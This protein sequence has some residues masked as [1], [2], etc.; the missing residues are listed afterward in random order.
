MIF[1]YPEEGEGDSMGKWTIC[2]ISWA[3]FILNGC[4]TSNA[5]KTAAVSERNIDNLARLNLGMTQS[6][7]LHIMRDPYKDESF[8]LLEDHYDVWFYLTQPTV[9]GQTRMVPFNL[10][11]LIFRNKIL[12]GNGFGYYN[13]LKDRNSDSKKSKISP[14]DLKINDSMK[15]ATSMIDMHQLLS[16]SSPKKTEKELADPPPVKT[17]PPEAPEPKKD[18]EINEKDNQMI[19]DEQ[20]QNFDFW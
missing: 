2:K 10:T 18:I 12:V 4:A 20:D 19:Q 16:M 1:E 11:P 13:W 17:S 3:L 7:V 6:Q 14:K 15:N 8:E 9:L 5:L